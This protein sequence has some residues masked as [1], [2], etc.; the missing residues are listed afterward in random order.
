MDAKRRSRIRAGAIMLLVSAILT[1][2]GLLLR[3]PV[4][5]VTVDPNAYALGAVSSRHIPAWS[6]LLPNLVL[7]LGAFMALFAY[8]E[9]GRADRWAFIG[10]VLSVAGNGLFLPSTGV[11]AF[12]SPTIA[13]MFLGGNPVV[14]EVANAGLAGAL[15]LPLLALSG[16]LLFLG[17]VFF[18]IA[19]W[20]SKTL[21]KLSSIPYVL[22]TLLITFAAAVSYGMELVG[23]GLYLWS[24]I[25][26]FG[27][28]WRGTAVAAAP[29][30]EA[31]EPVVQ[32]A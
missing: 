32:A 15:A 16:V 28:L 23:A 2:I 8:M 12:V 25:W 17:S 3:G 30:D 20:R 5:D 13:R 4:I 6:L 19:I 18:G 1:V 14:T 29:E 11:I 7:Q 31:A 26:L 22:H 9:N 10:M 27:A 21:P 24:A